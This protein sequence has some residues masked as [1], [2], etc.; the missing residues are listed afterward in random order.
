MAENLPGLHLLQQERF[1]PFNGDEFLRLSYNKLKINSLFFYE[2]RLLINVL[3]A[4]DVM[5][6][7]ECIELL[8]DVFSK[9][10]TG[11]KV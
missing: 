2:M 3:F 8:T 1:K 9:S 7:F 6:L 10:Q 11:D 5:F 4:S